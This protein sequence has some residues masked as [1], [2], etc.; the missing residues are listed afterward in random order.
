VRI[1]FVTSAHNS[2]SQRLQIEL[3]ALGHTIAVVL[4]SSEAAMQSAVARHAPALV[5]APMLKV[6]IPRSV[7]ERHTCL[8]VHPGIPGD[9]GP[10]SL[11]WAIERGETRWGVTV[12]QAIEQMDAGPIW[13]SR[14]FDLG[15]E[16]RSKSCLYRNEVTQ[17]AV[18]AVLE[19]VAR[20]A[21][22][23]FRPEALDDASP[24]VRGRPRPPMRQGDRAI[25]WASDTTATIVRRIRA[26]DSAPGVLD[27]SLGQPYYLYGAHVEGRLRGEPGA[28]LAQRDG[29]IC[30]GTVDGAVWITHLKCRQPDGSAAIKLPA[31]QA[32]NGRLR[33]VPSCSVPAAAAVDYP[34]W[35]E[36][37][38][39][40]RHRVG[41]LY[42]DF[43][44]GAMSAGQCDRLRNALRFARCRPTRVIVL[45]GGRDFFS[46]GIDLNTIEASANP[47]IE[48]WRN[49]VA[50]DN[51]VRDILLTSS[52]LM[53][54][55]LRGNAGAGGAMLALA[56]D[57]VYARRGV[58]LNPHYKG[59][60]GLYGSEYWTYC[61]PRRVGMDRALQ[62]TERLQPIG[63]GC[64]KAIGFLGDA[65]GERVEDF[66][67]ELQ[68]RATALANDPRFWRMLL[69]KHARRVADERVRPLE[70]YRVEELRNMWVN[71]FG[72][73][74]DYHDARRRFVFKTPV[75]DAGE[76]RPAPRTVAR[77]ALARG[78]NGPA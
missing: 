77:A 4:A 19:A 26:A 24:G 49:I 16:P 40:E 1:L 27:A 56:A 15:D 9:R 35:R 18:D 47:A 2:L 54:A 50:I 66:E 53:V 38:Y 7:W 34:T 65:F 22:G 20:F 52:H 68:A 11:D 76:D 45:A 61:L 32:L 69:D 42:F 74:R 78:A 8:I 6:A 44:N 12:L 64:A 3:Q 48:S 58:V 63:T 75:R 57:H 62:L 39:V 37:R 73:E 46:N 36:I 5:I 43:Y 14:A 17:A 60:G 55:G 59:M 71:F 28:I 72:P 33:S 10:S 31:V 25:D 70:S 13:A 51:L 23:R 41:Y 67:R 30:R 21:S 29:A